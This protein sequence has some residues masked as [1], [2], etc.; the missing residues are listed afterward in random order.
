[1]SELQWHPQALVDRQA[2]F[3]QLAE[4]APEDAN[5][6][7]RELD[8][9]L[10]QVAANPSALLLGRVAGTH[11]LVLSPHYVAVLR[12]TK[13]GSNIEVLRLLHAFKREP[14]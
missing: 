8:T 5:I 13:E 2:L 4:H 9:K 1:M 3:T 11:E 7:D 6:W 12:I 10:Q 14:A